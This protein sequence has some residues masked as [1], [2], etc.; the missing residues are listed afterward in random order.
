[1][2]SHNQA[3]HQLRSSQVPVRPTEKGVPSYQ[4]PLEIDTHGVTEKRS[5]LEHV[6][7]NIVSESFRNMLYLVLVQTAKSPLKQVKNAESLLSG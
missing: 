3:L 5:T 6:R 7:Y 2:T 4:Q 1:M